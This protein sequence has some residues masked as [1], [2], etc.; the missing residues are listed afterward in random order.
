[1][2]PLKRCERLDS[3]YTVCRNEEY[4]R[5]QVHII[6]VLLVLN[7]DNQPM[8]CGWNEEI[9]AWASPLNTRRQESGARAQTENEW[10]L[11]AHARNAAER[12]SEPATRV[13]NCNRSA[14]AGSAGA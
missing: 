13:V 10:C 6:S 7:D 1:M 2:P 12:L 3:Q 14:M 11:I 5:T 4:R 9:N 8:N